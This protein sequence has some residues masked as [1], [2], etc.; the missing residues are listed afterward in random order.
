MAKE[1]KQN[2]MFTGSALQRRESGIDKQSEGNS[3]IMEMGGGPRTA[4]KAGGS[5]SHISPILT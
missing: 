4:Q 1:N 2:I 3:I 5:Y